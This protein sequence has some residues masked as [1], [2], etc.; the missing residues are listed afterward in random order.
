MRETFRSIILQKWQIDQKSPIT[1][2]DANLLPLIL[3]FLSEKPASL[4]RY[5]QCILR[6][7]NV[8]SHKMQTM[9]YVAWKRS[10]RKM[11]LVGTYVGYVG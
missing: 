1:I 5:F 10:H 11:S 2:S 7:H 9:R 3:A 8:K 6:L 4:V